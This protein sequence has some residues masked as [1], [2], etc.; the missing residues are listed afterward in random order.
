MHCCRLAYSIKVYVCGLCT[1]GI[2]FGCR[3]QVIRR[4]ERNLATPAVRCRGG[5]GGRS[6]RLNT[7]AITVGLGVRLITDES[8]A[9]Y[10]Q[11]LTAG[12]LRHVEVEAPGQSVNVEQHQA[13]IIC[14]RTPVQPPDA[15]IR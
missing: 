10:E 8:V 5:G 4:G 11:I 7:G 1:F 2:I 9:D 14:G 6:C 13:Q 15:Q 12:E 3:H